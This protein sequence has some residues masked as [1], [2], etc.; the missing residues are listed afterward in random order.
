[1][2]LRILRLTNP[3]KETQELYKEKT[4][5]Y[6]R[7]G[8]RTLAIAVQ[9]DGGNWQ[10]LGLLPMFDPPRTDTAQTIAEA[11]R[12]GVRVKMLTGDA[13]AIAKETCRQLALGTNVY[14]SDKLMTGGMSGSDVRLSFCISW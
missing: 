2:A 9:E 13:V 12:L 4:G 8:F 3:G 7:R 1:M 6:A 11:G 5:E 14:D 10:L